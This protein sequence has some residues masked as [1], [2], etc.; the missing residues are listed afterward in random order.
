MPKVTVI[1]RKAYGGALMRHGVEDIVMTLTS[2]GPDGGDRSDG[3]GR[4]VGILYRRELNDA[5][6]KE[7]VRKAKMRNSR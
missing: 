6:D 3:C 1:T 2:R 7:S 4:R 5:E